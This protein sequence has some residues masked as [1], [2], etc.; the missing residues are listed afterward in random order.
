MIDTFA[1]CG[2]STGEKILLPNLFKQAMVKFSFLVTNLTFQESDS[3]LA[4]RW[5]E[6]HSFLEALKCQI[7]V[8]NSDCPLA[9]VAP[10]AGSCGAEAGGAKRERGGRSWLAMP[11]LVQQGDKWSLSDYFGET[12]A[13]SCTAW[14]SAQAQCIFFFFFFLLWVWSYLLWQTSPGD[15]PSFDNLEN[16]CIGRRVEGGIERERERL[17]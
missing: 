6:K 14:L 5:A 15:H 10:S 12:A 17:S 3:S 11:W 1:C 9:S 16:D 2:K 13:D 8:G 4:E 7:P